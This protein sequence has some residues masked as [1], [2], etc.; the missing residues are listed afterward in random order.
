MFSMAASYR[1]APAPF[2]LH[3]WAVFTAAL[4]V[5]ALGSGGFVT[6]LRVGMADPVWPTYPWHLLLISWDEPRPGFIIEHT[7]R[8]IDYLLGLACIVQAFGLWA[9]A[10]RRWL[11]WLGLAA[12]LGVIVQGLIGGFRV[13]L[14]AWLGT[15]LAF[16]HGCFGQLVFCVL[17]AVTAVYTAAGPASDP[18]PAAYAGRC[19]RAAL[20]LVGFALLQLVLGAAVR[21]TSGGVAQRLHLLNAFAVTAAAVWLMRTAAAAPTGRRVLGRTVVVLTAL[22]VVQLALGVEALFGR[23]ASPLPPEAQPVTVAAASLRTAHQVVGAGVLAAAVVGAIRAFGARV[24]AP[25]ARSR[26]ELGVASEAV[27]VPRVA[28]L[29]AVAVHHVEG[30]A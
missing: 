21:H 23:L 2:W 19:R 17:V 27:R 8:A 13:V 22:L 11:A 26:E 5:A 18:L 28:E 20:A 30:T 9:A 4:A 7:H 12:L 14:N 24:A 3:A 16:A 25:P 1:M 6:S 10:R 29:G 15:D